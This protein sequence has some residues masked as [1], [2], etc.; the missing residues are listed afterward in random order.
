[1]QSNTD[2]FGSLWSLAWHNSGKLY[3]CDR[4]A[5]NTGVKI[6]DTFAN[7]LPYSNNNPVSAGLPPFDIIFIE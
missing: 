4:K 5:T 7:D 2:N 3:V 6:Y 1:M